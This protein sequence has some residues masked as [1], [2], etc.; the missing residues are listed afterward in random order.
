M[1]VS[2][3]STDPTRDERTLALSR[4]TKLISI[5]S[6]RSLSSHVSTLPNEESYRA[7][8]QRTGEERLTPIKPECSASGPR[9]SRCAICTAGE[10]LIS[11]LVISCVPSLVLTSTG[12][13]TMSLPEFIRAHHEEIIREFS[14]F[15]K[16][17]M[18]PGAEMTDAELRDHA[19][20]LLIAV[21]ADMNLRQTPQEQHHKSQGLGSART[22]EAS[23]RLH[24]SDRIVH[25]YTFEAVLAEFRAL[26]ASVL[27]LY[28]ESRATDLSEVRRFNE[29]IDEALTESMHQFARET[30]LL[31]QELNAKAE[32]NTALVAEI[33]D[34]RMAEEKITALFR[35]LVSAQDEERRRIARDI[36]D[37]LGQ[38]ITALK[39]NLEALDGTAPSTE[40]FPTLLHRSQA[41]VR[42]LDRAIDFLTW[43]LRPA[44]DEMSLSAA[45]ADLVKSWSERFGIAAEFV[46]NGEPYLPPDVQEHLYRV[47]QE[48]LHNVAKHAAANHV[49]VMVEGRAAELVLLI[50][51]DGRGFSQDD[52]RGR[53][54]GSGLG[55]TSMRERA[56][57]VGGSLTVESA[58]GQGTS[59]YVRV[60]LPHSPARS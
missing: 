37:E 29:A 15:A 60:S 32:K 4:G 52:T 20:E 30:D 23:G 54:Q 7:G 40:L 47:T 56:A 51:D 44:I 25:G 26:R 28:E 13:R 19:R 55:L 43:E 1:F 38:A 50:E 5:V 3:G 12:P 24:A 48:A 45:L 21:V 9:C 35:R 8:V 58:V 10:L 31:R 33:T 17:L 22:M 18:P 2:V 53:S 6:T 57:L 16:T 34:R 49:S 59:I 46:T 41:L 11:W 14:A 42:D 36:H 39:M 27:R